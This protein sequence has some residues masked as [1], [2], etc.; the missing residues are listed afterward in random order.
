[1]CRGSGRG[2]AGGGWKPREGTIWH[3]GRPCGALLMAGHG[4]FVAHLQ[5]FLRKSMI[6]QTTSGSLELSGH[7]CGAISLSDFQKKNSKQNF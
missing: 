3:A 2:P 4:W 1:M 6:N 5:V 7:K